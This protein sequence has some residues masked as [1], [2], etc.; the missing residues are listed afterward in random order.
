MRIRRLKLFTDGR[1][2]PIDRTDR[3]RV[4]ALAESARRRGEITHSAVGILRELLHRF[5]NLKDGR[6]FPSYERLAEAAGCCARTVGRCIQALERVGLV[7][8]VNRIVRV[9][10]RDEPSWRVMRTSNSYDFPAIAKAPRPAVSTKGH[11]DR[12]TSFPDLTF[13]DSGLSNALER[14]R[15]GVFGAKKPS[16][17][18]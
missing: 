14:L 13:L 1:Q 10:E 9:R 15:A 8:W 16:R 4:M 11:F 2:A 5:A 3:A 12:G 18:L 7:T 17:G 6:C